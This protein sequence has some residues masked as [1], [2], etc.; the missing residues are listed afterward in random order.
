VAELMRLGGSRAKR[1]TVAALLA[2]ADEVIATQ[3]AASAH[4]RFWHEAA[5]P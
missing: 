2:R 3:F 5:G 4:S 1:G